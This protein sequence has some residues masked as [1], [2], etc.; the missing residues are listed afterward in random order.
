VGVILTLAVFAFIILRGTRIARRAMSKKTSILAMGI[1]G[2]ISIHVIVNIAMSLGFFP[3]T[4]LPLPFLS[5][6]GSNI[7]VNFFSV[8]LL[9]GIEYRRHLF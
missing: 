3:V 9:L 6:G 5:Y 8:G 2:L 7:L 4:G 1:V